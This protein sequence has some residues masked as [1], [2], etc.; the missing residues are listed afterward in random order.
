MALIDQEIDALESGNPSTIDLYGR[1]LDEVSTLQRRSDLY[2]FS[3]VYRLSNNTRRYLEDYDFLVPSN[4]EKIHELEDFVRSVY[5][6]FCKLDESGQCT[7]DSLRSPVE[8][9]GA[10]NL[11][12]GD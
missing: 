12:D 7:S 10:E 8:M 2:Q 1:R 11:G 6:Q 3:I 4:I 9:I 5:Q